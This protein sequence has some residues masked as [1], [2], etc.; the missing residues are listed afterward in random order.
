M[1]HPRDYTVNET[2]I[3]FRLNEAPVMTEQDGDFDIVCLMDAAS[4]HVLGSAFFDA[5]T[6]EIPAPAAE[7]LL[8][9]GRAKANGLPEKLLLSSAIGTEQ[10]ARLAGDAGI[11]AERVPDK[12]LSVFLS[13]VRRGFSKQITG[14]P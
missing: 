10:F 2:W 11:E 6:A 9:T 7:D 8:E 4:C 14:R 3:V 5:G 12:D 1:R 13:E